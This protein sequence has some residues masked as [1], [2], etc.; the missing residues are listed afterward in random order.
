MAAAAQLRAGVA[1]PTVPYAPNLLAAS[2]VA[3]ASP[4][5]ARP[6]PHVIP[7]LNLP[8]AILNSW[9][10]QYWCHPLPRR[11]NHLSPLHGAPR[12]IPCLPLRIR[13]TVLSSTKLQPLLISGRQPLRW[14][15]SKDCTLGRAPR[16]AHQAAKSHA[17]APF[18]GFSRGCKAA[19]TCRDGLDSV[20]H[21]P[22][23]R[24]L[25]S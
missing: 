7:T 8:I 6:L 17:Y 15:R 1:L 22:L 12:W 21:W 2:M 20:P 25:L 9:S 14:M 4:N 18:P 5:R 3:S 19:S 13:H 24:I 23:L 16:P 11:L 10:M